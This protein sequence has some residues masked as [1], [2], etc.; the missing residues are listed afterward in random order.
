MNTFYNCFLC[1][2]LGPFAKLQILTISFVMSV[3]PSVFPKGATWFQLDAIHYFIQLF[4]NLS[5][6]MGVIKIRYNNNTCHLYNTCPLYDTFNGGQ[7]TVYSRRYMS[8]C[9][10]QWK[11][12][13]M[14]L[15][16]KSKHAFW[17]HYC[18]ENHPFYTTMCITFVQPD[19][20]Q[21]TI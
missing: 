2:V 21:M 17:S 15:C 8:A 1:Y 16:R 18:S 19:K 3:G 20:P 10:L 13:E 12:F 14:K 5:Q 6:S 11:M 7:C 9:A 4:R